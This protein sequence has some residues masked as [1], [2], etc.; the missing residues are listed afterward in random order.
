MLDLFY[1]QPKV[2][3]PGECG[4]HASTCPQP[5]PPCILDLSNCRATVKNIY[6]YMKHTFVSVI[7]CVFSVSCSSVPK[8]EQVQ[9]RTMVIIKDVEQVLDKRSWINFSL[10][11]KWLEW[12][13]WEE[14]CYRK[15]EQRMTVPGPPLSGKSKQWGSNKLIMGKLFIW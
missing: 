1:R 9:W 4:V 3:R 10:E 7:P 11:Q 8:K 15:H 13:K 14:E 12:G 5:L 6:V 2:I